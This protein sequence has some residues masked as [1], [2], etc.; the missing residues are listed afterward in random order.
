MLLNSDNYCYFVKELFSANRKF[1]AYIRALASIPRFCKH[2]VNKSS[3][4]MASAIAEAKFF[5]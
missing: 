4:E 1:A 5:S 3:P 2:K